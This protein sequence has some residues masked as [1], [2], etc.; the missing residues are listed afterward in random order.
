MKA[1]PMPG[2]RPS[3]A[4][5]RGCGLALLGLAAVC[6]LHAAAATPAIGR[7][8]LSTLPGPVYRVDY[9]YD[10]GVVLTLTE[11]E[12]IATLPRG[13]GAT[14]GPDGLVYVAGVGTVR[15][16][17]P[18]T[19]VVASVNAMNNGNTVMFDPVDDL[20]WTGWKDS[21]LSSLPW[22]PL[23]N[24]TPH[25]VSGD[26]AGLTSIAFTPDDG[27]FYG[28]GGELENGNFGRVDLATFTSQRLIAATWA[29]GVVYDGFSGHLIAAG[30]GR[31]T[32]IAPDDPSVVVSS[33][34]DS[35]VGE[36]YLWLAADGRG[37]LFGTRT[38][39]A[40]RLVMI[41][42]SASGRIGAA[43]SVMLSVPL[44]AI[45]LLS[46]AAAVDVVALFRNGFETRP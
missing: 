20:L 24:G 39:A 14:L 41:D 30:V 11:P 17:D 32:Q 21:P 45:G 18:D 9:H 42:Y 37:H 44:P 16:I 46:G 10:G 2:N 8:Y 38:G 28:S 25:V 26:D 6:S 34:D 31:A 33:R 29:T 43:D 22:R 40:A 5:R 15:R 27:V 13:G 23:G 1:N 7:L 12:L 35:L 19:G 3:S 4:S 36:N